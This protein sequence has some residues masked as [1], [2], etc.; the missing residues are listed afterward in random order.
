MVSGWAIPIG[1]GPDN[2]Q[3]DLCT[4]LT[5]SP[6]A[7]TM[8]TA[9]YASA[10]TARRLDRNTRTQGIRLP[11]SQRAQRTLSALVTVSGRPVQATLPGR[12]RQRVMKSRVTSGPRKGIML[13]QLLQQLG[14]LGCL[15]HGLLLVP[16]LRLMLL[17]WMDYTRIRYRP[18]KATPHCYSPLGSRLASPDT[19]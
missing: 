15:K 18:H 14:G 19:H 4:A 6:S 16:H 1:L 13:R 7:T 11:I 9:Q 17:M 5:A 8:A 2:L 10:C 12:G 3:V